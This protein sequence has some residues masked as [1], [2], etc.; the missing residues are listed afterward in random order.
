LLPSINGW[1]PKDFRDV[2]DGVKELTLILLSSHHI[3][4]A[5]EDFLPHNGGV[6]DVLIKFFLRSWLKINGLG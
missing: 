3:N 1:I 5:G 2:I 6:R 4:N